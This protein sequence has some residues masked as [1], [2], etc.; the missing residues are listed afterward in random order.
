VRLIPAGVV[1]FYRGRRA[2][3]KR[4]LAAMVG[5]KVINTIDAGRV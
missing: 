2:V 1:S 5:L 3:G 4:W